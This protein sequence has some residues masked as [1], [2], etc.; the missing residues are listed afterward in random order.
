MLSIQG[1][2]KLQQA[3]LLLEKSNFKILVLKVLYATS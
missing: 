1:K 3:V 2:Y